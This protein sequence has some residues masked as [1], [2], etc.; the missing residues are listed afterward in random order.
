MGNSVIII[1]AHDTEYSQRWYF[2][3]MPL[4]KHGRGVVTHGVN[5]ATNFM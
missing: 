1:A 2:Q 3:V 4:K 5:S